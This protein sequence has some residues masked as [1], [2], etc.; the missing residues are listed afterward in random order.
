MRSVIAPY[1][2]SLLVDQVIRHERP[3]LPDES[4]AIQI[5]LSA[6]KSTKSEGEARI[7]AI[8]AQLQ[9]LEEEHRVVCTSLA[10]HESV[11]SPIHRLPNEVLLHIF[12]LCLPDFYHDSCL[13]RNNV[14]FR[15]ARTC[16]WWRDVMMNSPMLWAALAIRFE[17]YGC[18]GWLDSLADFLRLSARQPLKILV[19]ATFSR[20]DND[21]VDIL[22]LLIPH[23]HRWWHVALSDTVSHDRFFKHLTPWSIPMLEELYIS[24][25]P[26]TSFEDLDVIGS[27]PSLRKAELPMGL[28]FPPNITHAHLYIVGDDGGSALKNLFASHPHL[29]ECHIHLGTTA[30]TVVWPQ[31]NFVEHANLQILVTN[32]TMILDYLIFPALTTFHLSATSILAEPCSVDSIVHFVRQSHCQLSALSVNQ[33]E[34][35]D[36]PEFI[37]DLLPLVSGS[38]ASLYLDTTHSDAPDGV[39]SRLIEVMKRTSESAGLF[40]RLTSLGLNTCVDG[41]CA[42]FGEPFLEMVRSRRSCQLAT[43]W[44]A[45]R[46]VDLEL[47]ARRLDDTPCIPEHLVK[48][49]QELAA[50]GLHVSSRGY[51][52][53]PSEG[54]PWLEYEASTRRNSALND[55]KY[56]YDF[57]DSNSDSGHPSEST[58]DLSWGPALPSLVP[59]VSRCRYLR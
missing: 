33:P 36:S 15:L 28:S 1:G 58:R 6:L 10:K 21:I 56:L 17:P 34:I 9:H 55:V 46:L 39:N 25:S 27:A 45:P 41:K 59:H 23:S 42:N 47:D 5:S 54:P 18:D 3:L 20:W 14:R 53:W 16:W 31:S 12:R 29:V 13:N 52:P 24:A 26:W 51:H 19:D 30:S 35:C 50:K 40:P 4:S 44:K 7:A 2:Q 37:T 38:V 11:F 49:L 48:G 8:R 22:R 43:Q 32:H 57:S